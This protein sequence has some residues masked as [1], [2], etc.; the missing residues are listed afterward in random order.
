MFSKRLLKIFYGFLVVLAF[1]IDSTYA[2]QR[3]TVVLDWFINPNHA[4]LLLAKE[5]GLFQR[6]GLDVTL[7]TPTDPT[8]PPKWVAMKKADLALDYQPQALLQMARGLPIKQVG[9]LVDKPLN[10]LV[11]L[12]DSPIR[13]LSSINKKR[14]AYSAPEVDILILKRM[15]Q[16][17]GLSLTQ[18]QMINVHYNLTQALLSKQVDAAIGM[19]RNYELTQMAMLGQQ[20]RAFYPEN[21]GVP[22]YSELVFISHNQNK[23]N[24]TGFFL[25]LNQAAVYLREHPKDSW[26]LLITHYP[27]LK[28]SL[29]QRV[30]QTTPALF[31][32]NFS[33]VDQLKCQNLADFLS[34]ESSIPVAKRLCAQ[35]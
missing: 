5:R 32:V 1:S 22:A 15:L 24:L 26:Q 31:P 28:T 13:Q 17:V 10:C 4:P 23:T 11:V 14:I 12:A 8:D 3:L 16:Q 27:E 2:A 20:G 33:E 25:A 30:W 9:T 29:N 7:I 19:M 34:K 35:P 21:Y 18:V 6:Y